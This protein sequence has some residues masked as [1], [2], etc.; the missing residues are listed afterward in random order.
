[1]QWDLSAGIR[2][3]SVA[4]EAGDSMEGLKGEARA[5]GP[6]LEERVCVWGSLLLPC[7]CTLSRGARAQPCNTVY[8]YS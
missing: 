6:S 2:A 5:L 8:S 1:M 3:L 7:P 4:R